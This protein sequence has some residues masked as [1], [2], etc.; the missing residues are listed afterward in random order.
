MLLIFLFNIT[1]VLWKEDFTQGLATMSQLYDY[2]VN[3]VHEEGRVFLK[4]NLESKHFSA[5]WFYVDEDFAF[6]EEDI[7]ELVM[8]VKDKEVRLRYFYKKEGES[9]YYSG[10]QIISPDAEYQKVELPFV[11]AK[12]L[13]GSEYPSALTP[14]QKPCLYIFI[15]GDLPGV[16]DVEI[17]YISVTR[18]ESHG[19]E[20]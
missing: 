8:K 7:L 18:A 9:E 4:A 12:P 17:D 6:T 20:R 5:A 19:E 10:V 15:S 11:D 1:T 14:G 16:F 3:I 2:N 13:Y